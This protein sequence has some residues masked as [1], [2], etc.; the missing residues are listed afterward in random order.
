MTGNIVVVV[1]TAAV[2]A[3]I[4]WK[5]DRPTAIILTAAYLVRL[6]VFYADI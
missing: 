1:I 2:L 3:C 4:W 5:A 6:L